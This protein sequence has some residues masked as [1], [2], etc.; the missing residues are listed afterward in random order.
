MSLTN[1]LTRTT[2]G[3]SEH[4]ITDPMMNTFKIIRKLNY[5]ILKMH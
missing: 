3:P 4:I 2:A 1:T 5:K